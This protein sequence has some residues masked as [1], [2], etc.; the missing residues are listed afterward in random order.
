MTDQT[1][2]CTECGHEIA[3]SE[4]LAAPLIARERAAIEASAQQKADAALAAKLAEA[5]DQQAADRARTE[6]E[7]ERLKAR[8]AERDAKLK[9]AQEAELAA[10]K[11]EEA[12]KDREREMDLEV[13]KAINQRFAEEDAKRKAQADAALAERMKELDEQ[14]ALKMQEKDV[15]MQTLRDQIETLKKKSEQG[16]MQVQGE[17]QELVLETT[18]GQA[19]PTDDITPVGKGVRG[20]DCIQTVRLA[21]GAAGRII[22]E[23]KR[24]QN[25]SND[26]PTK[27]KEDMRREGA[28]IAVLATTA[29]PKDIDTFRQHDGVWVTHHRYVVPLAMSLRDALLQVNA[30]RTS[31]EGQATK[32]EQVYDYL[33]GTRFRQRVEAIVERFDALRD[34]LERER[35]FFQKQWAKREAQINGVIEATHGMYGDLEGIAGQAMPEIDGFEPDLLTGPDAD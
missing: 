5:E 22:W 14:S 31:T 9:Q 10:L 34:D 11:R 18:L 12:L 24:T 21:T 20:A 6:A 33:T 23:S 4:S 26:W 2:T 25:W 19:F 15:Q 27:L 32:M 13:Q 17:A 16:S 8:D 1:I 35:K 3:L 30:A 29:L 7:L 28:D